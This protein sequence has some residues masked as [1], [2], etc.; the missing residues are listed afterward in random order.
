MS[1]IEALRENGDRIILNPKHIVAV[2]PTTH[3]INY[4]GGETCD[5]CMI[6]DAVYTIRESIEN[7]S[8]ILEYVN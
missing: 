3:K 2:V 8:Y 4:E 7:I 5:V 6:N 1:I